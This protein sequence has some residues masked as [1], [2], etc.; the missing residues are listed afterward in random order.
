MMAFEL[1]FKLRSQLNCSKSLCKLKHQNTVQLLLIHDSHL[2]LFLHQFL[3]QLVISLVLLNILIRGPRHIK[4]QL[5]GG[6]ESVGTRGTPL[7]RSQHGQV[8]RL[9]GAPVQVVYLPR[10]LFEVASGV[11]KFSI[12]F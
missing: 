12:T 8:G 1:S 2:K 11:V 7:L 3:H 6:K 10:Q 5:V 4:L 9:V